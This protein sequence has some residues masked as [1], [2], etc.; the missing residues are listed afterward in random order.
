MSGNE[1]QGMAYVS[2]CTA[3]KKIVTAIVDNPAH[4]REVAKEVADAIRSGEAV[5][6]MPVEDVRRADFCSCLRQR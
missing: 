4:K 3:C 1:E 6:R 5:E 2:R